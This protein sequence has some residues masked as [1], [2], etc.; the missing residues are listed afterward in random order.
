MVS[1][2]I[3]KMSEFRIVPT[4]FGNNRTQ[5]NVIIQTIGGK[6]TEYFIP[7]EFG[8]AIGCTNT[9]RIVGNHCPNKK[10]LG[11]FEAFRNGTLRFDDVNGVRAHSQLYLVEEDELYEFLF[12]CNLPGAKP[13]RR[14][15]CKE[16]LPQI[17]LRGYYAMPGAIFP[18][19]HPQI[20]YIEKTHEQ[21]ME[22]L[23][24]LECGCLTHPCKCPH[25]KE[26]EQ[27]RKNLVSQGDVVKANPNRALGKKGGEKT[28]KNNRERITKLTRLQC[29][30]K[31][32]CF[33]IAELELLLLN[34]N[35]N[36]D[37][38]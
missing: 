37:D 33:R 5:F 13:F 30:N 1:K 26:R 10:T 38:E 21:K 32:S 36:G 31:D 35:F 16:V 18:Q 12:A 17:R 14:W 2:Y 24:R 6:D 20:M 9:R 27:E 25:K 7:K 19:P 3:L 28:Q 23:K 8:D 22:D 11:E 15:V 34:L 4:Y 29:E